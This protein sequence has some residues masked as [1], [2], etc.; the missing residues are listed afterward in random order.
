MS[1]QR[2]IGVALRIDQ[3]FPNYQEVLGGVQRYVA[4]R[5][6]WRCVVDPD[7][8]E[9]T[10]RGGRR[11]VPY[12]GVVTRSPRDIHELQRRCIPFVSTLFGEASP[13]IAG[14]YNNTVACGQ[15][16]ADHFQD[17][18]FHR[19]AYLG[20]AGGKQVLAIKDA[21]VAAASVN[22]QSVNIEY[23]DDWIPEDDKKK[24]WRALTD[25]MGRFLDSLQ[26][27][28]GVVVASAWVAR[29]LMN[30]CDRRGWQ[31]PQDIAVICMENV[32]SVLE[33]SPQITCLQIDYERVGYEAA[34]LLDRLMEG[35]PPEGKT[36]LVPPVGVVARE[37]TD[38]FA[39]DDELVVRALRFISSHLREPLAV[40]RV[41]YEVAVSASTLQRRFADS[42]GRGVGDEI[43]RLR[44][45]LAKRLL[46]DDRVQI[47]QVAQHV[48]FT[49]RAALNFLF[50]RELRMSPSEYRASVSTR[51]K[52]NGHVDR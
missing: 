21:F 10:R 30:L 45:E 42:L 2:V 1:K 16:L 13:A 3:P 4:E 37:S 8:A 27:P 9:L 22:G 52:R 40:D 12:D 38:H 35:E 15:L 20:P 32:K 17:R 6:D 29:L 28:V 31:I 36:V 50:R 7:L 41:A 26:R 19:V 44:L 11:R 23:L 49:S 5:P 39:V 14:V 24:F 43:R 46:R 51:S 18:G 48:G 47:T 34:A 33:L 25:L